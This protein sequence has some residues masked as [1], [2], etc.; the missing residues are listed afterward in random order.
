MSYISVRTRNSDVFRIWEIESERALE[1]ARS[2]NLKEFEIEDYQA[3]SGDI[4][5]LS[6]DVFVEKLTVGKRYKTVFL[7][8]YKIELLE[9]IIISI[10]KKLK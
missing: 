9:E 10:D 4:I 2:L 3:V 8:Y 1:I 5:Y 6:V 7:K